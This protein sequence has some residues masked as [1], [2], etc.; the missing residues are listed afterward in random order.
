MENNFKHTH[1]I[2]LTKPARQYLKDDAVISG[3]L[4]DGSHF[5]CK[6]IEIEGAF[7]SFDLEDVSLLIPHAYVLYVISLIGEKSPGFHLHAEGA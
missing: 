3:H 4:I 7:I 2:V 1:E 6:N 5:A